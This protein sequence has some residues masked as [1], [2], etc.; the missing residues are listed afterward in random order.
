MIRR[1]SK[2]IWRG[3]S[4]TPKSYIPTKHPEKLPTEMYHRQHVFQP[5]ASQ[6]QLSPMS[7]K[8]TWLEAYRHR[9]NI[10]NNKG[11]GNSTNG[12]SFAFSSVKTRDVIE[13]T[14]TDSFTFAVLPFKDDEWFLDAYINASGRL[15]IGQVFQDLDAL[16]GVIAYKHCSPAEPV[17]VTASVD[18]IYMLKRLEDISKCNVSLSGS[19]TWSGRSSMEITIRAAAHNDDVGELQSESDITDDQVFLTANFTF[20]ARDPETKRSFPINR[21]VP[22]TADERVDFV[23]AEKFNNDKKLMASK[24]ALN[25]APPSAEEAKVVHDMWIKQREY[26][27]DPSLR[28]SNVCSMA[29]T[30]IYSTSMMQPQYRNMHSYMI[31]GG[32]LLRQTFE[33]AYACTAGFSSG[34]PRFVS[35]DSTTFRNPVPVGS[36]LYLTATVCYT[37]Q[38]SQQIGSSK[39]VVSGTLV[40]VRVDSKIHDI[41][42]DTRT[43]TGQFTYSYFVPNDRDKSQKSQILPQSYNEMMEYLEGRRKAIDTEKFYVERQLGP[44]TE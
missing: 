11:A 30:R 5:V 15:R 23:R 29:D 35:L 37:Q 27:L 22:K 36:V 4:S 25:L 21:L 26:E 9:E 3:I 24:T 8:V 14:R 19:V 40:Q 2:T 13:K 7:R 44:I 31:F 18:R 38:T 10:Q 6:S 32:Y 43:D 20:A 34:V 12:P 33:L 41:N 1:S 17:I 28:P 39:G 16:A 42:H